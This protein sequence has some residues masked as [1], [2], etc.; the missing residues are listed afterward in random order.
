MRFDLLFFIALGASAAA[1]AVTD[2]T[3]PTGTA[4]KMVKKQSCSLQTWCG[5]ADG[6]CPAQAVS[7]LIRSGSVSE[8]ANRE[9]DAW[10]AP[11]IAV[12]ETVVE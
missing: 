12:D 6:G 7:I 3:K 10:I 5:G 4:K 11:V 9:V 1:G 2:T 8:L